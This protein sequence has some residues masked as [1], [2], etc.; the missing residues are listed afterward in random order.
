VQVRQ[1]LG[2]TIGKDASFITHTII[3]NRARKKIVK[4]GK[5]HDSN[6]ALNYLDKYRLV[7]PAAQHQVKGRLLLKVVVGDGAAVLYL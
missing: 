5:Y 3:E 6:K 7:P 1:T 2:K 4:R